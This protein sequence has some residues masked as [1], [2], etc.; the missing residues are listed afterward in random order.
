MWNNNWFDNK[1]NAAEVS[2]GGRVICEQREEPV[3][4]RRLQTVSQP[5]GTYA[6]PCD[7]ALDPCHDTGGQ[8]E[9]QWRQLETPSF[10]YRRSSVVLIPPTLHEEISAIVYEHD[11]DEDGK[12]WREELDALCDEIAPDCTQ[13]DDTCALMYG[14]SAHTSQ[15]DGPCGICALCQHEDVAH[16]VCNPGFAGT[17][18]HESG[19]TFFSPDDGEVCEHTAMHIVYT[20]PADFAQAIT[21]QLLGPLIE[22]NGSDILRDNETNSSLVRVLGEFHAREGYH[23]ETHQYTNVLVSHTFPDDRGNDAYDKWLCNIDPG[24]HLFEVS[25]FHPY[26]VSTIEAAALAIVVHFQL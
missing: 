4:G 1:T 9:T 17:L 22:V 15:R 8:C 5:S 3:H 13:I 10:Y 21:F 16:C 6:D 14:R 20:P 7:P 11:L 23:N 26:L 24:V 18:C 25:D 19:I 12:V 2:D